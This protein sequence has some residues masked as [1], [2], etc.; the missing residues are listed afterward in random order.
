MLTCREVVNRADELI[1]GTPL[2]FSERL[3]LKSH[4]MMCQHCGRYVKQLG[5][6]VKIMADEERDLTEEDT[7]QVVRGFEHKAPDATP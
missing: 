4:L 2:T 1:D 7:E 3:S 5:A 6:L